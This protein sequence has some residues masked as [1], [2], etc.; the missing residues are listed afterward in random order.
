M[1]NVES[2]AVKIKALEMLMVV[3]NETQVTGR[4]RVY[5]HFFAK[6]QMFYKAR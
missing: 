6:S 3:L 2:K 5:L 1:T 4:Y